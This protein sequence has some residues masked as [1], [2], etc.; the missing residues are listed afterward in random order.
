MLDLIDEVG[1]GGH[2]IATRET[3][4]RCREEIWMPTLMDRDPWEDWM[5]RGHLTMLDRVRERVH[6]ILETHDPPPLPR[7]AED[8]IEAVLRAAEE[9]QAALGP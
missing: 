8:E 2:F 9:R 7:G 5:A 1:P 3:A 6:A 4:R